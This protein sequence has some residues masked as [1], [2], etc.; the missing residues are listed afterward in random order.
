ML[1]SAWHTSVTVRR[2]VICA[3]PIYPLSQ[4][5]DSFIFEVLEADSSGLKRRLGIEEY[6]VM[7]ASAFF[8]ELIRLKPCVSTHFALSLLRDRPA[9]RGEMKIRKVQISE[10]TFKEVH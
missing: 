5:G 9:L 10:A 1:G 4:D 8:G 6:Y 7:E 2:T 3:N